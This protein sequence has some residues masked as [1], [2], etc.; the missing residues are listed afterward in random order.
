MHASIYETF[1]IY[2]VRLRITAKK[3]WLAVKIKMHLF[4]WIK[5]T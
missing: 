5:Y 2:Y 3:E 1:I 4:T